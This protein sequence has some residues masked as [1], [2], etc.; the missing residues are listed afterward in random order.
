MAISAAPYHRSQR[1]V[2]GQA[3]PSHAIVPPP[4][5]TR[6]ESQYKNFQINDLNAASK[7]KRLE[8]RRAPHEH[9]WV[10]RGEHLAVGLVA[11]ERLDHKRRHVSTGDCT[12]DCMGRARACV[13]GWV[14]VIFL[15]VC[16]CV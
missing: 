7:F 8:A 14:C 9:V 4:P 11:D 13:C 15:F 16:V 1:C 10:E 6:L 5:P 3:M 2:T 12:N